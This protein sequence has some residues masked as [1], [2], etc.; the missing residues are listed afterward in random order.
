MAGELTNTP[1][2]AAIA[3]AIADASGAR[4]RDLPLSSERVLRAL[5]AEDPLGSRS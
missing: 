2:A 3:N 1:V 4:I 5:R